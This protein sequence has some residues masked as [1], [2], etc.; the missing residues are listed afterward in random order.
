MHI[1]RNRCLH[2]QPT[3]CRT[4]NRKTRWLRTISD[5]VK[6]GNDKSVF[7]DWKVKMRDAMEQVY[8]SQ[9]FI[10]ILDFLQDFTVVSM[11]TKQC[12]NS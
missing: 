3:A 12:P 4:E 1:Q 8:L 7:S 9:E 11:E 2:A 10:E 6:L 5:L